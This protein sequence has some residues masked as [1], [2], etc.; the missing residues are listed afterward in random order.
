[1]TLYNISVLKFISILKI[2]G[3]FLSFKFTFPPEHLSEGFPVY[4]FFIN[5]L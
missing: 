3:A 5:N 4:L 1:M 2:H